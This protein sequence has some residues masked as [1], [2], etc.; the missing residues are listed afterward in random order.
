MRG[1]LE[2]IGYTQISAAEQIETFLAQ[3]RSYLVDIRY[4]P[5]SKWNTTWNRNILQ[6]RYPKRYIHLP[7]LGN[8][9]YAHKDLPIQLADPQ[10]HLAHL[11]EMLQQGCS[12]L[13][14]CACKE[15]ARCHRKVVYELLS[16]A[17]APMDVPEPVQATG[18]GLVAE[19]VP[20]YRALSF[21][22]Q[23][24]SVHAHP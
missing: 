12:Y 16:A 14:L 9:N 24:E 4:K 21:W 8:V 7:G 6:A 22:E 11:V 19:R 2:T 18:S 3:P 1:R 23:E 10:R 5:Y 17:L 15:Y 20:T 13:L